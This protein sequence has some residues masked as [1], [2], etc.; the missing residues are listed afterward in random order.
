MT[1][2]VLKTPTKNQW[3]ELAAASHYQTAVAVREELMSGDVEE[4]IEG[5]EELIEALSRSD[6]RELSSQLIRL[7]LHVVKWKSQP[8]RRSRSWLAS[9]NNARVEI[10][11]LL[12][13]EPVLKPQVAGLV[14]TLFARAQRLAEIEMARKSQVKS[15]TLQ[16]IFEEEYEL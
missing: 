3:R 6:R 7:M 16:E 12:E 11:I 4:A 14:D 15:L 1:Q 10:E 5:I 2:L 8:A 9:I 13:A